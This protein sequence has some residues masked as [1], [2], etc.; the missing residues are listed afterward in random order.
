MAGQNSLFIRHDTNSTE[1]NLDCPIDES[2]YLIVSNATEEQQTITDQLSNQVSNSEDV[3]RLL[4]HVNWRMFTY[5]Y[6]KQG[7]YNFKYSAYQ[8][9]HNSSNSSC[10]IT[11]SVDDI[12]LLST[13]CGNTS[14]SSFIN[15]YISTKWY[16]VLYLKSASTYVKNEA[17]TK[18]FKYTT[19]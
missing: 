16:I 13:Q 14:C 11:D 17:K 9:Q 7:C 3:E 10:C 6:E 19:Y 18:K 4:N 2:F 12:F 5:S 8:L 1:V 15:S